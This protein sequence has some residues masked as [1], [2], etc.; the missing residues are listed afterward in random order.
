MHI[1]PDWGIF[2]ALIVSFL[3]FWFIFG[4]LFFRPFLALLGD[5]ERRLKQLSER[6]EQLLR[7]ERAAVEA[8][9]V[10]LAA[11]RHDAL[12]R[13]EAERRQAEAEATRIIADARD[14]AKAELNHVREGIERDFEAAASQLERLSQA[15]GA[16][17]AGRV[18]ERPVANGQA[19]EW[20]RLSHQD[21]VTNREN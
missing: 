21:G 9:E 2:A 20:S 14:A 16:E 12:S 3:I 5:R 15:L 8:R 18:L 10:G 17:L 11:V 19:A 1:P 13:R 6:T 4:R 7:D